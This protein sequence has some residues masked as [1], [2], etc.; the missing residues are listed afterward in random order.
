MNTQ[1]VIMIILF[2]CHTYEPEKKQ[3]QELYGIDIA[4]ASYRELAQW[5]QT[6][7][8]HLPGI[9]PSNRWI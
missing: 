6:F 8:N 4:N 3:I 7:L 9:T 1:K 2:E 5:M